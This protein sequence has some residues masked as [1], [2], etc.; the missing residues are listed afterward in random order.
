MDRNY[1]FSP[2]L[3]SGDELKAGY[4]FAKNLAEE[5]GEVLTICVNSIQNC[6]QFLEKIFNTTTVNKLRAYKT[7][8]DG[9]VR[10]QLK[11]P[12]G[13]KGHD[14]FGVILALH[15]SPEAISKL[16]GSIKAH[17]LTIVSE[18]PV[19]GTCAHLETWASEKSAQKLGTQ[20]SG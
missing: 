3:V 16:E 10:V 13:L 5:S 11:S 1:Y 6:D 18:V 20:K 14:T 9:P 12:Q 19:D 17:S 8:S 4:A 7:I 2:N 15:A